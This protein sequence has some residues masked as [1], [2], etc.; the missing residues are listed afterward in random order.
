MIV[1]VKINQK[2]KVYYFDDN[3]IKLDIG[4][5]V[6]VETDKSTEYGTVVSFLEEK[7]IN[8]NCNYNKVIRVSSKE[9]YK[10]YQKNI[11]DA[12]DAINQCKELINKYGLRMNLLDASYS[13]DRSQLLFRFLSEGRVDF[14]QLAREL[15]SFYKTRIELRQV[16]I[17]D[18]AKEIGGMGPCGRMQCCSRFLKSFE[19]I[20]INMAKNQM[21]ALNPSKINGVCG[22]LLCCLNYENEMYNF[23][24]TLMPNVGEI[25]QVNQVQGKVVSINILGRK[26]TILTDNG[27]MEVNVNDES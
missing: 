21:L 17:R 19:T 18:K 15:G 4:S 5:N 27:L 7:F 6:I 9:D 1:G 11:A 25:V 24:R 13:F 2:G 10:K 23:Y 3:S 8:K 14:R 20:T 16:G 26:Y 22:R 12:N